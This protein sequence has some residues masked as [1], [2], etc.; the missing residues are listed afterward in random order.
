MAQVTANVTF[1]S[2]KKELGGFFARPEGEG[3]FPGLVV[4]HEIFGLTENIKHWAERFANEGYAALAVDLFT[5]RNHTVC[6]FSMMRGLLFNSLDHQGI[7]DLKATLSY[8]EAQPSVDRERVGAV[9]YCMGGSLAIAWAC[10]D[11]R[12]KAI[13]PYYAMNPKPQEALNRLCPVVGSY[14]GK[15]F[16]TKAGQ[17]LD[18]TLNEQG[19][20]HDIKIYPDAKHSFCN[21]DRASS[22][23]RDAAEDSWER[24]TAFFRERILSEATV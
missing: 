21:A 19:I 17:Q 18:L 15:D 1:A 9:G 12:L 16:T 2:G 20:V 11:T 3:P 6:M 4:I 23:N 5:G 7:R 14:P 22:Y 10:T 13:A 8:L 24:V